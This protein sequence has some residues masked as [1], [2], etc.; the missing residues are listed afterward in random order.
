MEET[1]ALPPSDPRRR[2]LEQ[3]LAGERT[4]ADQEW[5]DLLLENESFRDSLSK[6][7]V[8]RDLEPR[9]LAIGDYRWRALTRW[10]LAAAAV[11]LLMLSTELVRRYTNASRM[12][13]VA[14]LA[15]NN[16]LNHLEDHGV[17]DQPNRKRE[18]ERTL[19]AHVGFQVA[20]PELDN[21]LQL[22][23]GRE[24]KLGTHAVA[25][26]LWRD[27]VGD[28]SVF[29]FQPDHFGLPPT[30]EP[31]LVRTPQPAGKQHACGAWI[32]TDGPYG[33]VLTGDPG[34]DLQRLS[35]GS[36]SEE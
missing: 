20:V 6:V 24:C 28:Y 27:A 8:P 1:A 22:A 4:S 32:W 25:F 2:A 7:D 10:G 18:L 30:I 23:G 21:G 19:T 11:V 5:R 9:L 31:T 16:H 29:Q 34:S 15:I 14:L 3:G 35:P 17:L 26:T 12:R 36:N 33:Y 13:T